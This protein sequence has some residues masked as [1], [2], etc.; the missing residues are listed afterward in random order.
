MR[1][2]NRLDVHPEG[3]NEEII[4][5]IEQLGDLR[6]LELENFISS[7]IKRNDAIKRAIEILQFLETVNHESTRI[8]DNDKKKYQIKINQ[9]AANLKP[10][11]LT[12]MERRYIYEEI[13]DLIRDME[14]IRRYWLQKSI[15]GVKYVG[16]AGAVAAAAIFLRKRK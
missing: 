3:F 5:A 13:A 4:E 10:K 12:P 6:D 11:H 2:R 9:L 7:L 15:K 14:S 8:S 16:A 1:K